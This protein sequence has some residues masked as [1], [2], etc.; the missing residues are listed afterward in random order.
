MSSPFPITKLPLVPRCKIL[1]FFD[2]GDLL[3]ISLCSK[4]MAQTVRDIHITADLHYLT[5]GKDN[6]Q[7][8]QIQFKQEQKVIYWD[9]KLD[10]VEEEMPER[11]TVGAIVFEKCRK[12]SQREIG[13]FQFS[14]YHY[15][16]EDSIGEV[17]KH[18]F[19]IF[20]TSIEIRLSV[21]F[22]RTLRNLFSY[23]HLQ[24]ID[25]LTLLGSIMLQNVLE[26]IFSRVKIRRKLWVE[27]ETDDEYPILQALHVENLHLAS[28]RWMT[29]D[30]LLQLTCCSVD[31]H[32]HYFG[33]KDLTVFA[34]NWL[35]NK[36]SKLEMVRF[37]WPND[38]DSL[39]A[40][41]EGLKT[42]KWDPK[43][44]EKKF[45]YSKDNRLHRIDCTKGLELER[46]D[47]ELATW[48]YEPD[49]LTSSLYFLVW[50]ERFPEKK[51]LEKLPKMLAPYYE[52]L[53]QLR[54]EYDDSCNLE[55]LLSN[56]N[57]KLD[58]FVETYRILRGMDSEVRLSS[59]GRVR[60]RRIF[61]EMYNIID[62]QND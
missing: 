56:P 39:S 51:R 31:F 2:Y 6:Q 44:R 22:C 8:I 60:R 19:Y 50:T 32:E 21:Q 47:G 40:N 42:H 14:S 4:R 23:E 46:D 11:R 48:I 37:G 12:Y 34:E 35:N 20:P 41:F 18:L 55:W 36:N 1:K 17:S 25:V 13:L 38:I 15:D 29:R 62:A 27:P 61:D 7:S 3:D 30:H 57:L 28:A 9:F 33:W 24:N 59:I 49:P 52:Q 10:L 26:K 53:V 16:I 43:Q 5:L 58:E 54:K 45:L